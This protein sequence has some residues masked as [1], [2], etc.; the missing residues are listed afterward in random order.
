MK[1]IAPLMAAATLAACAQMAGPDV[2]AALAPPP[3][4]RATLTLSARGVQLY[5]CQGGAWAFVAPEAQLFDSRGQRVGS[6]GAGPHWRAADGSRVVGQLRSRADAPVPGAVPWL[7][8]RAQPE[9][10]PGVFSQVSS[11]QR[12]HTQGGMAPSSPCTP[13]RAGARVR[14]PYAA[15]YRF[16]TLPSSPVDQESRS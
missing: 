5:E 7:L 11:I 10:T 16:F 2:P 4:E 3:G 12:I 6:H 8:L 1:R 9:G 13:E 14:V 15:D